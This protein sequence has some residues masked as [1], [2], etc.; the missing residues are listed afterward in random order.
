MPLDQKTIV[1]AVKEAKE[2]SEKRKFN[3]SV[4]LII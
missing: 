4:E 2:K 3:Q 1:A